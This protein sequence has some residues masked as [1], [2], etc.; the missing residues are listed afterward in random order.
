VLVQLTQ[1]VEDLLS[2][3]G[4]EVGNA[5]SLL[6]KIIRTLQKILNIPKDTDTSKFIQDLVD[7]LEQILAQLLSGVEDILGQV[8]GVLGGQ[9]SLGG[10][11]DGI[12]GGVTGIVDKIKIVGLL[13]LIIIELKQILAALTAALNQLH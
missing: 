4:G 6:N 3:V 10:A 11:L 8:T 5:K 2:N 7:K 1:L 12:I 13:Q 9:Q